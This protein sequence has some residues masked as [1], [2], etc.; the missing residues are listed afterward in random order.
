M[1]KTQEL[2]I[3]NEIFEI[4]LIKE[5]VDKRVCEEFDM[6]LWDKCKYTYI[7]KYYMLKTQQAK[8]ANPISV[9]SLFDMLMWQGVSKDYNCT[10][11][12][13][14]KVSKGHSSLQQILI[15]QTR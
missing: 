10:C 12:I 1:P 2:N 8:I 15:N 9:W 6:A 13:L 5:A 14:N 7:A 11:H 4:K 3:Q